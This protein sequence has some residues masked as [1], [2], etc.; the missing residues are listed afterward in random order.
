MVEHGL[1][2][3]EAG[4]EVEAFS[5]FGGK[6]RKTSKK[7]VKKA[8]KK[9]GKKVVKKSKKKVV[10]K[11]TRKS[12]GKKKLGKKKTLR[13][14]GFWSSGT[15]QQKNC[16][17][18]RSRLMMRGPQGRS[19]KEHMEIM[20]NFT[21]TCERKGQAAALSDYETSMGLETPNASEGNTRHYNPYY[22]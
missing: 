10:G 18:V 7:H 3:D 11:K 15:P 14:G 20:D 1:P 19:E 12:V 13:G 5:Q 6:K 9:T 8:G 16:R 21:K 2:E 22:D 17:K 4:A